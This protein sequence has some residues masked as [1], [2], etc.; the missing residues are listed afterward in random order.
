[1]IK[2][3]VKE[4]TKTRKEVVRKDDGKILEFFEQP[5]YAYTYNKA[6]QLNAYPESITLPLE[7]DQIAYAPGF[8]TIHPASIYRD[9]FGNLALSRIKL[10][11][12]T[13]SAAKA[14]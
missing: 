10:V 8:Y 5:A 6:G 4:A 7:K 14:A 11:P 12:F 3:E 1:M 2:I 9:R 13:A